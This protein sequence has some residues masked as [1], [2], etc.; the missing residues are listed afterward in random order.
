MNIVEKSKPQYG[1][2]YEVILTDGSKK[3]FGWKDSER[4]AKLYP[5]L[6]N[7][8]LDP[9]TKHRYR[10][11]YYD[12]LKLIDNGFIEKEY[13]ENIIATT[14]EE[15]CQQF[16]FDNPQ[17]EISGFDELVESLNEAETKILKAADL[18]KL[19]AEE[20]EKILDEAPVG[21]E[22]SGI[23]QNP[24][25][26]NM[27]T[28]V[29]KKSGYVHNL[30]APLPYQKDLETWW[31]VG[32][33]KEHYLSNIILG[34]NQYYQIMNE[35]NAANLTEAKTGI[36]YKGYTVCYGCYD[37]DRWYVKDAQD[38]FVGTKSGFATEADAYEWIDSQMNESIARVSRTS[39]HSTKICEAKVD[40][41]DLEYNNLEFTQTG[42]QR[43]ADDWDEWERCVD[44][45]YRVDKDDLI[46]FLAED[47]ITE[48]DL[49]DLDTL[50]S[51]E[52]DRWIIDNFDE[53]FEKYN[54]KI[55]D[56]W[57]EE[58]IEDATEN[59]ADDGYWDDDPYYYQD[60][61]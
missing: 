17:Y 18:S 26:F 3:Q 13:Q 22:I 30:Y 15:A 42:N 7:K 37:T 10:I 48:E 60:L 29:K 59:Y 23:R 56:N 47:C 12:P 35:D 9:E 36:T 32:G 45:T 14:G 43:D 41:V 1:G 51:E 58:A 28:S 8:S 49:K 16:L 21:T 34:K 54:K 52:I 24:D 38:R 46:T 31:E 53:L 27:D 25:R 2:A 4:V 20:L 39:T 5:M 11:Y 57:E 44:W 33:S 55:L 61:I 19:S 40:K 50:P 6:E